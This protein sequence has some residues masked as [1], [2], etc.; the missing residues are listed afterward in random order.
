MSRHDR[1]E[2]VGS[3]VFLSLLSLTVLF[4]LSL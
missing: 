3:I 1:T 4:I 2:I